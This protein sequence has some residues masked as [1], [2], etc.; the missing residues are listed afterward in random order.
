MSLF[1]NTQSSSESSKEMCEMNIAEHDEK[2]VRNPTLNEAASA[3]LDYNVDF[4]G[5]EDKAN[6]KNWPLWYKWVLI[7]VLSAMNTIA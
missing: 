1:F 4:D 3:P 6:P 2:T 7:V 5:S